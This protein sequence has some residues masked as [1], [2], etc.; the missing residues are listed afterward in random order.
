M[1]ANVSLTFSSSG[2]L[3]AKANSLL[4][5]TDAAATSRGVE[6]RIEGEAGK[7]SRAERSSRELTQ[8]SCS[9][10]S[11]GHAEAGFTLQEP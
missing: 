8:R 4:S 2:S 6:P 11:E 5:M 1:D 7:E 10:N 3:K 9:R